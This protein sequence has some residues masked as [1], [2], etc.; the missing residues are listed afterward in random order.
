MEITI[1]KNQEKSEIFEEMRVHQAM[2]KILMRITRI[3]GELFCLS[4]K[5]S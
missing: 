2:N 5:E 4:G 3:R 1:E